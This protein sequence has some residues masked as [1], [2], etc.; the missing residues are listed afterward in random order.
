M[1]KVIIYGLGEDFRANEQWIR[2]KYEIVGYCDRDC[3]KLQLKNSFLPEE[4]MEKIENCD[5]IY[6]TSSK[7][8]NEIL[9]EI[10]SYKIESS[11]VRF[12][13]E[14]ITKGY[15]SI[16]PIFHAQSW[17]GKILLHYAY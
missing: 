15:W 10:E 1:E 3:E 14:E 8:E 5:F 4:L 13:T 7:Y 17:G 9:K 12:L 2:N 11:K 16:S 6:I